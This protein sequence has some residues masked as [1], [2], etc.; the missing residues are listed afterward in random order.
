M[1]K[2]KYIDRLIE[3]LK[4]IYPFP[5]CGLRYNGD[6][7]RLLVMA[8]L[9][10]QCTDER[11][12]ST[13]E[14]L[15]EVYKDVYSMAKADVS[16][17]AAMIRPCGLQNSKARDIVESSKTIVEKYGGKLPADFDDILSLAGVGRKIANLIVGDAY[18]RPA[19]VADTHCIRLSGRL[20]LVDPPSKNPDK[21][22]KALK[23]LIPPAE[24]NDFCHRLVNLGRDHCNA[25]KP[26]CAGCPLNDICKKV[27]NRGND[28]E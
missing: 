8:R 19:I 3:R 18:G 21:V 23:E 25:R 22:E 17:V 13:S 15:F 1:T 14:T 11:V 4:E 28:D 27:I 24:Q 7:W 20:G 2:N 6:P 26:D 16:D 12:N 9:S 10:A 5:E